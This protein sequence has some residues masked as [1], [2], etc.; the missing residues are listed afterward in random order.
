MPHT[1]FNIHGCRYLKNKSKQVEIST[2]TVITN[3]DPFSDNCPKELSER[4]HSVLL[5]PT[6]AGGEIDMLQSTA[7]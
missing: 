4:S 6:D 5:S 3:P 2:A 1:N 7:M